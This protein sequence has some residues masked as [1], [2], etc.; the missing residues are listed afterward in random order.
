MANKRAR[1][2]QL[3]KLAAR[4]QAERQAQQ[5]RR[6]RIV[7]GITGLLVI[8]AAV[9]GF[10]AIT[11]GETPKA[12]STPSSSTSPS[13]AAELC[14]SKAPKTAGE[15][16][17]TFKH[18]PE[19]TIDPKATYTA[20]MKTSCG[21]VQMDLYPDVAPIGVNNFV[22]LAKHGFYDGLTFHRI[23]AGFVV[24]GGDPAGDGSGGPGYQFKNEI[25]K[26]V[27][28]ADAGMLAY[29]NSGVDTNGSQF[30]ITLAPQPGLD[31][32]ADASYTIFGKVTKGMDVVQ[33]MGAVPVSDPTGSGQ[34]STP[35]QP[36]YIDS[37]TIDEKK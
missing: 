6:A 27:T 8:G 25:S 34:A 32:T 14:S 15:K 26:K 4:R 19:M 35:T 22:F 3:A 9:A 2:R 10:I 13:A 18:A 33:K 5:R 30:F 12:S 24:Q 37:V 1:D 23:V 17:P 31:P 11:G 7:G 28:F 36:V 21:T 16:K 29:A 20:T